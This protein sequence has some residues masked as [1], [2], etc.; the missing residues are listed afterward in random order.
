MYE[1]RYRRF[2][3]PEGTWITLVKGSLDHCLTE[4][5][6]FKDRD[7]GSTITQDT[8]KGMAEICIWFGGY[9]NESD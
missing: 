7:I 5:F 1:I 3:D 6:H 2:K 4:F 9:E 8:E